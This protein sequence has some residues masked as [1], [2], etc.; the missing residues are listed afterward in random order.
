M[1]CRGK[2]KGGV[3]GQILKSEL[4]LTKLLFFVQEK[5]K[6]ECELTVM[7]TKITF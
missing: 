1:R 2:K 6:K 4:F 3:R 5:K 7:P